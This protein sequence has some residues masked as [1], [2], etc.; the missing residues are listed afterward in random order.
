[1]EAKFSELYNQ[2]CQSKQ[3]I[4]NK[5]ADS[6][7]SLIK[8]ILQEELHDIEVTLAKLDKGEFGKC[9]ISGELL[10]DQLLR[11][12]PT[13]K[14]YQDCASLVYFFRKSFYP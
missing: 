4:L 12:I 3:E 11:E 6:R 14:S 9:E 7:P 2:L 8:P 10:P 5:L 13:L 1:M